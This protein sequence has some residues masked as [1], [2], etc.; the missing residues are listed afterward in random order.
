[1]QTL[2]IMQKYTIFIAQTTDSEARRSF[3][4]TF[5]TYQPNNYSIS[6]YY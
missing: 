6:L 3:K 5:N 1:M 2:K 4:V